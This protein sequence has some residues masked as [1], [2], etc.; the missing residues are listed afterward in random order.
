[1]ALL[2]PL[3]SAT[4]TVL[5]SSPDASTPNILFILAVR[6]HVSHAHCCPLLLL[7]VLLLLLLLLLLQLLLLPTA[8]TSPAAAARHR[9]PLLCLHI[10]C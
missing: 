1:M 3:L 5:T 6:F 4:A 8:A 2:L 9:Q 7:L 10:S